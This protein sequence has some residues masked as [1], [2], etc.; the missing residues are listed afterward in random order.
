MRLD[1]QSLRNELFLVLLI[2]IVRELLSISC[3]PIESSEA[4]YQWTIFPFVSLWLS[5]ICQET[6][7]I[8]SV[9]C[10]LNFDAAILVFILASWSLS[11]GLRRISQLIH[12]TDFLTALP[13]S[14]T[15]RVH[16][17]IPY[18]RAEWHFY[19]L[20]HKAY[21]ECFVFLWWGALQR[22][23]TF[24]L[25]TILSRV[26]G[27]HGITILVLDNFAKTSCVAPVTWDT[28][29]VAVGFLFLQVIIHISYQEFLC[30]GSISQVHLFPLLCTVGLSSGSLVDHEGWQLHL[31]ILNGHRTCSSS[32][33]YNA[34]DRWV[35][36]CSSSNQAT[37]NNAVLAK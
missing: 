7:T 35:C 32:S 4:G 16:G 27:L 1:P 23:S 8:G 9:C 20:F 15:V 11:S 14:I 25:E 24:I 30:L 13:I 22:E 6:W 29:L 34:G 17:V 37:A 36:S 31:T 33:S 3:Y 5:R 28:I 2:L 26:G 12:C 18:R 19:L 10:A 21:V